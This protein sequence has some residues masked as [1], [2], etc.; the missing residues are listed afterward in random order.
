MMSPRVFILS[1]RPIIM[2]QSDG[3]GPFLVQCTRLRAMYPP[4]WPRS[5]SS[6]DFMNRHEMNVE[7]MLPHSYHE[8]RCVGEHEEPSFLTVNRFWWLEPC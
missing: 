7:R 6:G 3:T 4:A 1:R 5:A 2:V 8:E